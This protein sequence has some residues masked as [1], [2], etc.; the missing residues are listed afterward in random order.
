MSP[1]YVFTVLPY[2]SKTEKTKIHYKKSLQTDKLKIC[3]YGT[4]M[5][6]KFIRLRKKSA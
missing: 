2:T 3:S 4:N 1:G 5:H 6:V